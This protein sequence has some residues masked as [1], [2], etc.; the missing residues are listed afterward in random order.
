MIDIEKKYLD[1]ITG[2]LKKYFNEE[3]IYLYGSRIKGISRPCSDLDIAVLGSEKIN[4]KTL[5]FIEDDFSES[6]IPFTVDI[7]DA[8]RV[9]ESFRNKIINEGIRIELR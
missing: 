2:I 6:D 4:L 5:S 8:L 1:Q 9:D 7:T 3:K